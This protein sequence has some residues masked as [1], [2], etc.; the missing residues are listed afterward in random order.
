LETTKLPPNQY[1]IPHLLKW[2]NDH[3]GIIP[4][5]PTFNMN[6][7]TLTI[8]GDIAQSLILTWDDVL[9]LPSIEVKSDFH[10]VER[11]SVRNLKWFGIHFQ[12]LV[13]IVNP[14]KTV[15]YVFFTCYD[16]YTTSLDLDC[17]LE[18]NV[19]LAYKL[20]NEWLEIPLGGPLRL[21]IPDKYAYKSAMW[22]KRIT[23]T[24]V[25]EL[26][27]WEKKGYSDTANVWENDRYSV[28][29]RV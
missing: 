14:N 22:I 17:L 3:P 11:W 29:K 7:W 4:N 10:C 26:G 2:N 5:N 28:K 12:D 20:N 1:E 21:I 16:G 27:Y 6:K 18:D 13:R 19:L 25:L 15:K 23:F 9:K 24:Q 8:D